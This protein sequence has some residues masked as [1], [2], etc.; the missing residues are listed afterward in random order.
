MRCNLSDTQEAHTLRSRPG[1]QIASQQ[2]FLLMSHSG[3]RLD[4]LTVGKEENERGG[5]SVVR[6][7]AKGKVGKQQNTKEER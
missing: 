7:M 5:G 4:S 3:I 2:L 1:A 6:L